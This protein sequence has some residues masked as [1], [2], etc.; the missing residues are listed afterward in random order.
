MKLA[1]RLLKVVHLKTT[2]SLINK[3]PLGPEDRQCPN[4]NKTLIILSSSPLLS[5]KTPNF[6]EF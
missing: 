2:I 6:L 3:Y 4:Y 1:I 5:A